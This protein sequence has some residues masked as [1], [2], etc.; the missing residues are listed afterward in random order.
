MRGDRRRD[1]VGLIA[2]LVRSVQGAPVRYACGVA[3]GPHFT[4]LAAASRSGGAAAGADAGGVAYT[5]AGAG[6][7]RHAAAA[8]T[9]A[10][11][12]AVLDRPL[13]ALAYEALEGTVHG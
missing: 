11:A 13:A 12:P 4:A 3:V 9:A 10:V 8:A 2:D 7:G 6:G 1:A 5:G